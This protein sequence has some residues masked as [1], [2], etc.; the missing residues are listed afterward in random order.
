M[1]SDDRKPLMRCLG[2][3]VGHVWKGATHD[4]G[5]G[6]RE[7]F[8]IHSESAETHAHG[9]NG[10]RFILRRTVIDEVEVRAKETR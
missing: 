9:A 8:Q 7:T 5:A 10:E 2:E 4:P 3:F 6:T 1:A